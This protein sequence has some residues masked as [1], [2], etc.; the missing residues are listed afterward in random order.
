MGSPVFVYVTMTGAPIEDAQQIVATVKRGL[1]FEARSADNSGRLADSGFE[2]SRSADLVEQRI[3]TLRF[4]EGFVNAF[5][6]RA[7]TFGRVWNVWNT[8]EWNSVSNGESGSRC[9]VF[10]KGAVQVAGLADSGTQLQAEF[11]NLPAGVR[12]FVSAHQLGYGGY[13]EHARLL[14]PGGEARMIEDVETRELLIQNGHALAI[15][16]VVTPFY[17]ER[18]AGFLDFAVF[19]SYVA[20]PVANLPFIGTSI[21]EGGFCPQLAAYSS[22][23]PIPMFISTRTGRRCNFLTLVP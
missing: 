7:P 10:D 3:A 15:W 19:A 22:S 2:T 14:P 4:T 21:V 6:S 1:E 23:G 12:I 18:S 8:H 20:D 17:S 5:K 9:A 13:G 16:E 11:S